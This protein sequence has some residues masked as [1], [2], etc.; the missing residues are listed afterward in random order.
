MLAVAAR[1]RAGETPPATRSCGRSWPPARP[2]AKPEEHG[3]D[4]RRGRRPARPTT[5]RPRRS[6]GRRPSGAGR[7]VRG[8]ALRIEMSRIDQLLDL[9]SRALV[10]QGQMGAGLIARRDADRRSGGAAPEER[11]AADRA[12]GLGHRHPDG[13]GLDVLSLAR[14]HGA[15]RGPRP[16]QAGAPAHRGRA[17]AGRHRHRRERAGRA[18]PPGPQRHRPRHRA[19]QRARVAAASTPKGRSPSAPPRTATRS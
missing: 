10:V 16:A 2:L 15:R 19:A 17:G 13:P 14:A 1:R 6:A 18:H 9:A 4:A 8:P 7:R 12:A 3:D 5:R 11:A